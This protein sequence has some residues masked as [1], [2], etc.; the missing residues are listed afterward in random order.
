MGSDSG[1]VQ[2]ARNVETK[3]FTIEVGTFVQAVIISIYDDRGWNSYPMTKDQAIILA[4]LLTKAV[5]E[6]Q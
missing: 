1:R 6:L 4:E 2:L 5:G 3:D